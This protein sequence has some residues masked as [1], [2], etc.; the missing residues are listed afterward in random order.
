MKKIITLL[1]IMLITFSAT[2]Q[3]KK[4]KR[5]NNN[6]DCYIET[7]I[8]TFELSQDDKAKLSD[9]LAERLKQRASVR[10]KIK[11][12]EISKEEGK[13]EIKAINQTYFKSFADLTGTPKKEI[14]S[15]EKETKKKCN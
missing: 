2:S 11:K 9:L 8:N 7:A 3:N 6:N 4:A 12:S 10:R 13:T 5:N 14:M 1:A 15:F